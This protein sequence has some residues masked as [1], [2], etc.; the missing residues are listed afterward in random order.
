ME[1]KQI[2]LS[3]WFVIKENQMASSAF[4]RPALSFGL[5]AKSLGRP[6][7]KVHLSLIKRPATR[8][9]KSINFKCK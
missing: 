8:P 1:A 4:N 9:P 6:D 2:Q 3:C 7:Y 5:R